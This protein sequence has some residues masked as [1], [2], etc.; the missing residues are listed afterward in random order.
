MVSLL[1]NRPLSWS[2]LGPRAWEG[3]V[4]R[5]CWVLFH[6][7]KEA[8]VGPPLHV[9]EGRD[10]LCASTTQVETRVSSSFFRVPRFRAPLAAQLSGEPGPEDLLL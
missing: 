9:H 5:I 3:G 6:R 2:E 10:P 4:E 1:Y 7:T 8:G